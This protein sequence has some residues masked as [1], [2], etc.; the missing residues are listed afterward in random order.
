[1][2]LKKKTRMIC[3]IIYLVLSVLCLSP[4][5]VIIANGQVQMTD[6]KV[7]ERGDDWQCPSMEERERVINEI[8]DTANSVIAGFVAITTGHI[9]TCNGTPGWR[10][11]AFINMTDTSYN[12]PIGLNLTHIPRGY[13]DDLIPIG[14]DVLQP[15]SV[16]EVYHTAMCVG[17]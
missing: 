3:T 10:S 7:L 12:C 14:L 11:V 13:V 8:H 17:G 5:S 1:M 2:L 4:G 9:H 15:H 6:V 16:L